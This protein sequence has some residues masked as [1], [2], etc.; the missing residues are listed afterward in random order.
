MSYRTYRKNLFWIVLAPFG[1][2]WT[3]WSNGAPDKSDRPK[4]MTDAMP[5]IIH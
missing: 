1:E 5:V 3:L 4:V 2:G